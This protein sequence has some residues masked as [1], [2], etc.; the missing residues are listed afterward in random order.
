M[1]PALD[2]SSLHGSAVDGH[3]AHTA[4]HPHQE[5]QGGGSRRH[6]LQP[7][8]DAPEDACGSGAGGGK[9][10]AAKGALPLSI[11][12]RKGERALTHS[13]L[14]GAEQL[15]RNQRGRQTP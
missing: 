15:S 14:N 8:L 9:Q 5:Q 6:P 13:R 2:G 12:P 10:V 4:L 7:P 1:Q 3:A 11:Q